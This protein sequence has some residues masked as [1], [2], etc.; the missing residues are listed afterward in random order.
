MRLL[1]DEEDKEE[2]TIEQRRQL[3]K[4]QL[5]ELGFS[6]EVIDA[7][8]FM[9]KLWRNITSIEQAMDAIEDPS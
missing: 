7:I 9:N 6:N 5:L 1:D 8:L 4:L 2:V 3:I